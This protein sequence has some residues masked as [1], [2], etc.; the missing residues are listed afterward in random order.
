MCPFRE[1]S[2]FRDKSIFIPQVQHPRSVLSFPSHPTSILPSHL[3][4][5]RRIQHPASPETIVVSHCNCFCSAP[6]SFFT[7]KERLSHKISFGAVRRTLKLCIFKL[8]TAVGLA[9]FCTKVSREVYLVKVHGFL[10]WTQKWK[11]IL[12]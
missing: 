4:H 6:H 1:C 11:D 12:K 7:H 9:K 2:T 5:K 8:R 10:L 3:L